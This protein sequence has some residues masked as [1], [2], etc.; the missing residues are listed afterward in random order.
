MPS[1]QKWKTTNNLAVLYEGDTRPSLP[2]EHGLVKYTFI[3][4]KDDV[5]PYMATNFT[6]IIQLTDNVP[7]DM[8]WKLVSRVRIHHA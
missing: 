6:G 4:I 7:D 3:N 2:G 1:M 5:M 8:F